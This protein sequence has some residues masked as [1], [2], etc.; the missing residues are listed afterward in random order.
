[1]LERDLPQKIVFEGRSPFGAT[2]RM[3][4]SRAFVAQLSG[5]DGVSAEGVNDMLIDAREFGD[6]LP[7]IVSHSAPIFDYSREFVSRFLAQ[8]L[9]ADRHASR[10]A[11]PPSPRGHRPSSLR[12]TVSTRLSCG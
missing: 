3:M 8:Q 5:S 12:P 1:M 6:E 9:E 4:R 2:G 10:H 11:F 7:R